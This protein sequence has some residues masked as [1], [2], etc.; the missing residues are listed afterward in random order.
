M[1]GFRLGVLGR[2]AFV[3]YLLLRSRLYAFYALLYL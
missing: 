3:S 2:G 1:G